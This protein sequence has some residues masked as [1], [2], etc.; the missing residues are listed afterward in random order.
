MG[1]LWVR[2]ADLEHDV[3][4]RLI[5]GCGHP[6]GG[7]AGKEGVGN[8]DLPAGGDPRHEG[9]QRGEPVAASLLGSRPRQVIGDDKGFSHVGRS[10][11]GRA[12]QL[13]SPLGGL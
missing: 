11:A 8:L 12:S 5:A 7:T 9:R 6:G 3:V 1:S 2:P 10:R 13:V 4:A